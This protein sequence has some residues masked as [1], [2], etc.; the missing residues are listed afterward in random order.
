[1]V[2]SSIIFLRFGRAP[3]GRSSHN[4]AT[5]SQEY[6]DMRA[7]SISPSSEP[8]PSPPALPLKSP[9]PAIQP[10][11]EELPPSPP[12][13]IE[14]RFMPRRPECYENVQPRQIIPIHTQ[15]PFEKNSIPPQQEPPFPTIPPPSYNPKTLPAYPEYENYRAPGPAMPLYRSNTYENYR[16]V[17]EPPQPQITRSQTLSERPVSSNRPVPCK[18][19]L[20]L[21][22]F[23]IFIRLNVFFS[24]YQLL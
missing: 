14:S 2:N 21:H 5:K 8:F 7:Q 13:K 4:S 3:E 11:P 22:F 24:L 9:P 23:L 6:E 12:K 19:L 1:M 16:P 10:L 17:N 15:N 20:L 18:S